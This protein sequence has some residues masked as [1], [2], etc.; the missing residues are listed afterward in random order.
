MFD[1]RTT[2][3]VPENDTDRLDFWGAHQLVVASIETLRED[4]GG[5]HRRLDEAEPWDLVLVDEAHR[6]NAD[7][8]AGPTLGYRLLQRINESHKASSMVFFTGTPHRGKDFGFYALL[9]LL[10]PD[11]FNPRQ[12]TGPQAERIREAVIR[13]NK[14]NVTD[15]EGKRLFLQPRVETETYR[16]TPSE[17]RFYFMLT[18]FIATGKAYATTLGSSKGEAVMLVLIAMQKLASSSVAAVSSALRGRLERIAAGRV[19]ASGVREQNLYEH[20]GDDDDVR[21]TLEEKVASEAE[22]RLMEQEE[23]RLREL[24]EAAATVGEETKIARVVELIRTRFADRSVLLFTEYKA[25]QALLISAL[26]QEFGLGCVV[27][28]NGDGRV[29]GVRGANG[30]LRTL[31]GNRAAAAEAFNEG[32]ARFLISTEAGGEGIDLQERCY[33]LIHVDLPWNPM[34]LHQRVGRLNRYG[35]TRQVEVIALRNPD[36]VEARIWEK[37]DE[38]VSTIMSSL[39]QAMDE[40]EDLLQLVLGMTS[41]GLFREVFSEANSVA[42]QGL[43][44]WF[45]RKTSTLGGQDAVD[46]VR[47]LIGRCARFDFGQAATRLPRLDLD[48]LH[49]FLRGMLK[50]NKRQLREDELGLAFHTP[51]GW[52][53]E[54]RVRKEYTQLTFNRNERGKDAASRVLGV[55]HPA[56]DQAM[57]QALGFTACAAVLPRAVLTSPLAIFKTSDLVTGGN[58]PVKAAIFGFSLN[59]GDPSDGKLFVDWELLELLN[60]LPTTTSQKELP[61]I[62]SKTLETLSSQGQLAIKSMMPS[63]DLGFRQPNTELIA[64]LMPAGQSEKSAPLSAL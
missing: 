37:L 8:Q 5:R 30:Q 7:E 63:L 20:L 24:V 58:G 43:S 32:K 64:L 54:P 61:I 51:D 39:G 18:E 59:P 12:P 44:D 56:V 42:P 23:G 41:P 26:H 11:L 25:T 46:A 17:A 38:K 35:Q 15:L 10:R 27:F 33:T 31:T 48:S 47:S 13:N 16:Y 29:D 3:Y 21:N 52:L 62:D 2:P 49:P 60:K 9:A 28:I 4:R 6:L 36:T 55:G 50:H 45:D 57:R 22:L 40:P 14:Q 34:R 53:G 1:I 19:K